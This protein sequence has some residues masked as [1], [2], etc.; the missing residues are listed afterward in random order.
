MDA[1]KLIPARTW[2]LGSPPPSGPSGGGKHGGGEES[3][4]TV[5]GL[6]LHYVAGG[7]LNV[8]NQGVRER[9]VLDVAG[10]CQIK[11]NEMTP[12]HYDATY[13]YVVYTSAY[14]CS[15]DLLSEATHSPLRGVYILVWLYTYI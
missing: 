15:K 2:C 6:L 4:E 11:S 12:R 8:Q 13:I 3:N 5:A 14:F 1:E 9:W 10:R 7:V